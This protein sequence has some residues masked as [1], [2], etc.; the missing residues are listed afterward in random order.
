MF[1]DGLDEFD[2]R[3]DTVIK[4]I[5]NVS[6]QEHVKICVSSRP[7]LAFERAFSAN[8]CL[9]LQDLT[10]GTIRE[11][12][13]LQLSDSV[14]QD[15]PN[16]ADSQHKAEELLEMIVKRAE[17][18]FL[19]AVLA[20]REVRDGLEGKAD[21]N[22]LA[23]SI[24]A[25][26]P[27]LETL[28]GLVLGRI[29]PYFRRDAARFLQ[30]VL[31]AGDMSDFDLCRLHFISSQ[32]GSQDA[33]FVYENVAMS[34]LSEACRTLKIRLLS[35]T[36]GFLELRPGSYKPG[37]YRHYERY[38]K[39]K[40]WDQIAF[41]RVDFIHRTVRDFLMDNNE[42]KSFLSDH[43][44]SQT[45]VHLC[46]AR[47]ALAHIIQHSQGDAVTYKDMPHPMLYPFQNVLREVAIAERLSGRAQ[48]KLMQSLDYAFLVRG[49][50]IHKG[51]PRIIN[52]FYEAFSKD[53]P[54]SMI[55]IVGMAA[56]A[57]MTIYV[58]EQLGLSVSSAG[59]NP[60]FT[61]Q[62]EYSK[63]RAAPAYLSWKPLDQIRYTVPRRHTLFRGSSYR[64]TL[65]NCL[66]WGED[67]QVEDDKTENHPLAETFILCCCVPPSIDL[68]RILLRAGANPM[69]QVRPM[70]PEPIW[71]SPSDPFWLS[72][73]CFLNSMRGEYMRAHGKSGGILFGARHDRHAT[74][75]DIFAVTKALL[76]HGADMNFQMK[77]SQSYNFVSYLKRFKRW[78]L[79]TKSFDLKLSATAMF[80]L[81]EC[82]HNEPE[83]Q[84]FVV[85]INPLI[86]RPN[87]E[88]V[89]ISH[90]L[91]GPGR[92]IRRRH[93]RVNAEDSKV[94]WP[95]IERWES[96]GHHKDLT[97]LETA[98]EQIYNA[99]DSFPDS[100][101]E[102]SEQ[103]SVEELE[104]EYEAESEEEAMV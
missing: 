97:A 8:P 1:I 83:F 50:T 48:T 25:L 7:L 20:V 35:H 31:F 88:I 30:I 60:C 94:L 102:F 45:Q 61:D 27:E 47:G 59:Y 55:D 21:L 38:Y 23:R 29:K 6:D 84:E 43:G 58:C 70:D 79:L 82:F 74:L 17:G 99:S 54:G 16:D 33:P 44:L 42:A 66:Q 63:I 13:N 76:A 2:G 28:F 69:V 12:I 37:T 18:V 51:R 86:K 85:A 19:W 100:D 4:M 72:W 9:R 95:I 41:T 78:D 53:E 93:C 32:N 36:A 90:S 101:D 104:E 26:P 39:R 103:E 10:F 98:M 57:D 77:P 62:D 67:A 40:D 5:T 15:V 14:Q 87:R 65:S 92:T 49:Y 64:Q 73:L 56:A 68:V 34:E 80:I 81:E 96:T 22:G 91:Q 46:I 24:Q 11:Y 71:S 3:Y 52:G 75:G 89:S